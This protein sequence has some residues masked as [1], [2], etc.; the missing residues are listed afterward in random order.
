[1]NP[2]GNYLHKFIWYEPARR[3]F[4]RFPNRLMAA[5][6][7]IAMSLLAVPFVFSGN[8]F[9]G[10]TL[11]LG[12]VAGALSETDD[13][14]RGRIKALLLTIISF[15]TAS[16]SVEL[17]RPYPWL[18]AI[19]LAGSTITFI[20]IG[21]LGERYRGI[22]F[23]A[24]LVSIYTMLG[25]PISPAPYWQPI[26]LTS[27]A[28]FYGLISLYL[29]CQ[30]P[31]RLLEEQL[32]GGFIA[33]AD[34]LYEKSN[35]FPSAER[36]QAII[37]HKLALLNVQ[38]VV[39]LEKCKEVLNSY[40]SSLKNDQ[41]ELLPYLHRF[42]LLQ[43]LHERAASSHERYEILSSNPENQNLLEG[44]SEL[45]KQLSHATRQLADNMLTGV[46]YRHPVS[47]NWIVAALENHLEELSGDKEQIVLLL[48]N[49]AESNT[50]LQN[51]NNPVVDTYMPRLQ[52]DIR[53]PWQRL[54]AQLNW[55][56]QR[57]RYAIRLTCS[58]LLG[59]L[60]IRY[61]HVQKGEWIL[62]TSLFVS[63]PTYSETRRKLFQRILG[64]FSGVIGGILIV[65]VLPT[66]PGQLLLM[67]ASAY[68]FFV[69][70][71]TNYAVAVI[72]I[73]IFV[74]CA[75]NLISAQGIAVMAPRI[76]DTLIGAGLSILSIR[77]LWPDWQYKRL[78]NLLSE[79]LL[80]NAGYFRAILEE[81]E[82]SNEDDLN[83]RIAR[84][85]AHIADNELAMAWRSMKVEPRKH[86]HFQQKAFSLTYL[87]HALLSYLSAFGAH[88]NFHRPINPD[89]KD[90]CNKIDDA[91]TEAG[92]S[93]ISIEPVDLKLNLKPVL[94]LLRYEIIKAEHAD[95]RQ[96]LVLL[97]NIADV[98]YQ[99]LQESREIRGKN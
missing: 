67:L 18:F 43:T 44:F 30:R 78:P 88:R 16:S 98:S 23:G 49:L 21:G 56:H 73:T 24:I 92:K 99:L 62:L 91:L 9:F 4:W 39:S 3:I 17:L 50:A 57:L 64:T 5:K 32:A 75:F 87:N 12:A 22:T 14:P 2:F 19:G 63:Q 40:A 65:Q 51:L 36:D 42:L 13:H 94:Y 35:L 38:V 29:L 86:Q 83:Y 79:A 31:W 68:A 52:H 90:L 46:P 81:Y 96:Q 41:H 15:F 47:L 27:G 59:Y 53:T 74:L 76:I 55:K 54:T 25:A 85:Q 48:H 7:T 8:P 61:F 97:L 1:M 45:L 82:H 34:Y 84:R 20:L 33:L 58:F 6:A 60:L 37:R 71:R 93:L 10:V 77:L 70:L 26:L 72:F 11:A 28:L 89:I 80:K 95:E 66:V 69:W